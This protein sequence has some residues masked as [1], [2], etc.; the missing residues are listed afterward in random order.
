MDDEPRK[1]IA[2]VRG[3]PVYLSVDA[4]SRRLDPLY[5][6]ERDGWLYVTYMAKDAVVTA[7]IVP[8]K[9]DD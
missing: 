7:E 6:I 2:T 3:R 8:L 4:D 1:P 9:G 5:I